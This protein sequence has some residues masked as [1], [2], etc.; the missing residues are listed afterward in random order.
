MLLLAIVQSAYY[1]SKSLFH[2]IFTK[3]TDIAIILSLYFK[4]FLYIKFE[5]SA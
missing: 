1:T 3:Y 5:L 4:K 2:L